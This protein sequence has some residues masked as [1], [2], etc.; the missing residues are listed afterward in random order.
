MK[1][2]AIDMF[3]TFLFVVLCVAVA[4][5]E[6]MDVAKELAILWLLWLVL[7][8]LALAWIGF[9]LH[10]AMNPPRLPKEKT[11]DMG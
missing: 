11:D 2:F 8:G 10:R 6:I 4:G 3:V 9:C 5:G 7:G 1:K